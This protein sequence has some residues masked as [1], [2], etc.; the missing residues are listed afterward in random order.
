[1]AKKNMVGGD[2]P[3]IAAADPASSASARHK[4]EHLFAPTPGFEP[5]PL[6]SSLS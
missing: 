2:D 5:T 1:M 3:S 6:M 4:L